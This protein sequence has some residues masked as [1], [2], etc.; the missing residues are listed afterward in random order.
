[1]TTGQQLIA[2][3]RAEG[4]ADL[5]LKALEFRFGSV[6]DQSRARVRSATPEQIVTWYHRLLSGADSVDDVLG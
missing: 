3:G 1:M 2:E 4:Q 5:L 6:D